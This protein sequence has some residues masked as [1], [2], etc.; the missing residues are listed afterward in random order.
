M[1]PAGFRK[2]VADSSDGRY[3]FLS[4]HPV[5]PC[6]TAFGESHVDFMEEQIDKA[7]A[8]AIARGQDYD[9]DAAE[10][11]MGSMIEEVSFDSSGRFSFPPLLRKLAGIDDK[12][13]F[14]GSMRVITI[15]NP[16]TFLAQDEKVYHKPMLSVRE[17]LSEQEKKK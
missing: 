4:A 6:L 9:R 17:F 10:I 13:V 12:A 5:L 16:D 8:K 15:W 14:L 2:T 11:N 3:L 1:L 7:E